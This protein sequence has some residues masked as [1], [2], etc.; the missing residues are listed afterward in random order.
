MFDQKYRA[1]EPV[2]ENTIKNASLIRQSRE[3]HNHKLAI[4]NINDVVK[5]HF[6]RVGQ[7]REHYDAITQ[8]YLVLMIADGF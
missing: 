8:H 3:R 1:H 4:I 7:I 6:M 5:R 2:H